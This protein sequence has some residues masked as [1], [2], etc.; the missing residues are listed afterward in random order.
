M[1]HNLSRAERRKLQFGPGGAVRY[2]NERGEMGITS[3][4][5]AKTYTLSGRAAYDADGVLVFLPLDHRCIAA[6][7]SARRQRFVNGDGLASLEAIAGLPCVQPWKVL[8]GTRLDSPP[9]DRP[10]VEISRREIYQEP[11]APVPWPLPRKGA[12]IPAAIVD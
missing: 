3:A 6:A 4:A 8:L 10:T 9:L 11:V 2:R 12:P 5:Q 1:P 7:A